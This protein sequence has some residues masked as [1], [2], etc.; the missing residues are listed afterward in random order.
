VAGFE[1]RIHEWGDASIVVLQ[2]DIDIDAAAG[3]GRKLARLQ[4]QST[5]FVDLWDVTHLD[6]IAVNVLATA[7]LR[8]ETTRWDFAII[9]P[10]G[11]LAA[12]EIE[13]AG[14]HNALPTFTTKHDA[15]AALRT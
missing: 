8:T 6:P 1:F 7:K 2:G 9:A 11:G 13:A 3:L 5:V 10:A 14:L 4:R 12:R 15:R